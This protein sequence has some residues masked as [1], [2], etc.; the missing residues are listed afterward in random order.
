VRLGRLATIATLAMLVGCAPHTTTGGGDGFTPGDGDGGGGDGG[1]LP[2]VPSLVSSLFWSGVLD[3]VPV[4]DHVVAS[5][6]YGIVSYARGPG[7]WAEAK[8]VAAPMDGPCRMFQADPWLYVAAGTGGLHLLTVSDPAT[9]RLITTYLGAG[10]CVVDVAVVQ[11]RAF[12]ADG[13]FGLR[14]VD[15]TDTHDPLLTGGIAAAGATCL[16][17]SIQGTRAYVGTEAGEVV[18][19]DIEGP[20]PSP[21]G[22]IAVS[23]DGGVTDLC[24][25]GTLL[26]VLVSDRGL[27]VLNVAVPARIEELAELPVED[28]T[29]LSL[30]GGLLLIS[31]DGPGGARVDSIDVSDP[32]APAVVGRC[33]PPRAL[34]VHADGGTACV[35]GGPAGVCTLDVTEQSNVTVAVAFAGPTDI[36]AIASTARHALVGFNEGLAVL[37]VSNRLATAVLL[38]HAT[39]RAVT[40]VT[41]GETVGCAV[42]AGEGE[43]DPSL[44][45]VDNTDPASPSVVATIALPGLSDAC[46]VGTTAYC[47]CGADGIRPVDLATPS[48][49]LPGAPI[50]L[51][52]ASADVIAAGTDSLYVA[53]QSA[54]R[55]VTVSLAEGHS[56][57]GSLDLPAAP[58]S[59]RRVGTILLAACG[60]RGLAVV[61]LGEPAAPALLGMAEFPGS[62]SSA[63]MDS[64]AAYVA[65][66]EPGLR[67][68]SLE[69]EEHPTPYVFLDTPGNALDVAVD[70]GLVYI[71]DRD[72]LLICEQ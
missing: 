62:A 26:Y 58:V 67:L 41:L 5:T 70:T 32:L 68:V 4:G 15:L 64:G 8:R 72:A 12:L 69:N 10:Q 54:R 17:V 44:A 11:H 48:S 14:Q 47:V 6:G 22:T 37:D 2:G 61:G 29:S 27:V 63:L 59:L 30:A 25:A 36:R 21:V 31:R 46:L 39:D 33:A 60:E 51:A 55:L 28:A 18:V 3:A 9:P 40:R 34:R 19:A 71:A 38:T 35:A 20:A 53:D 57:S 23:E 16:D 49:P 65:A 45:V 42:C 13:S 1:G 24:V 56:V 50:P 66:G 7:G 52:G 43:G